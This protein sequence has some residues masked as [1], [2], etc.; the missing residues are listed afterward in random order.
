M[1][2]QNRKVLVIGSGKSG[3]GAAALLGAVGAYPVL[4]DGNDKLNAREVEEKA[5][6]IPGLK[7]RIGEIPE[8]EKKE[9]A[10]VVI[11]PGVPVDAPML[12][13]YRAWNI[14][15][16]GEIELAYTFGKGKVA[17][18]TGTNGKTT[19]TTLVGEILG[20]FYESVFVV[21]NIGNPYTGEVLSM[22]ENSVTAAEISSFQLETLSPTFH[23]FLSILPHILGER[24]QKKAP[25]RPLRSA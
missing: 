7:V 24:K 21:G 18:I 12:E 15:I 2:L 9:F 19:T 23:H 1:D 11:S 4:F 8:Q 17:A 10:L 3:I 16:W 13:E 22:K 25:R 20:A 14:P 6:P 5:G